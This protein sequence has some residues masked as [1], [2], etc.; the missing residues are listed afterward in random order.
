MKYVNTATCIASLTLYFLLV[1]V[2]LMSFTSSNYT[3]R[4][5]WCVFDEI[6]IPLNAPLLLF[7]QLLFD[8]IIFIFRRG[9]GEPESQVS[10]R[11]EF[12]FSDKRRNTILLTVR[13]DRWSIV[14]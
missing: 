4:F 6:Y 8:E 3:E 11:Y 14:N 5:I 1:F 2:S 7:I 12:F 10:K 9:P 13:T